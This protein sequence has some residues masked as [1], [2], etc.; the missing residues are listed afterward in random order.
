MVYYLSLLS[1]PT[2]L[3][4]HGLPPLPETITLPSYSSLRLSHP[5]SPFCLS[6]YTLPPLPYTLLSHLFLLPPSPPALLSHHYYL[7]LLSLS[8]AVPLSPPP[9]LLY[10]T[11]PTFRHLLY[12][13]SHPFMEN[14]FYQTMYQKK[15]W[16]PLFFCLNLMHLYK[17]NLP[18]IS[19]NNT[20][21]AS[22][23]AVYPAP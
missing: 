17:P 22:L 16:L 10:I 12:P 11:L 13:L 1:L 2:I 14:T 23:P 4:Y 19:L 8:P 5:A 7:N 3:S 6:F 21:K 15:K 9:T 20:S 18:A